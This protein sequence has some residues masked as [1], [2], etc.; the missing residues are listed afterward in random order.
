LN[1]LIC[2]VID[3]ILSTK[4]HTR[5]VVF[6]YISSLYM[7]TN[8]TRL[9]S[10]HVRSDVTYFTLFYVQTFLISVTVKVISPTSKIS[11]QVYLIGTRFI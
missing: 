11:V 10:F 7:S 3:L 4:V 2:I 6:L 9:S 1:N 5:I 8:F